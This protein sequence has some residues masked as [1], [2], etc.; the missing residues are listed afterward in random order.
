MAAAGS[1]WLKYNSGAHSGKFVA[2]A[3]TKQYT[4]N[5]NGLTVWKPEVLDYLKSKKGSG[6]EI[7]SMVLDKALTN[8]PLKTPKAP[9]PKKRKPAA[10]APAAPKKS[11]WNTGG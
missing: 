10:P 1:I 8:S 11:L 5:D 2:L 4:L 6:D 9:K 7:F 3:K